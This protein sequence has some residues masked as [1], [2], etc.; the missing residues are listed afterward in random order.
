[1]KAV[2]SQ[3]WPCVL[4]SACCR[5]SACHTGT[6]TTGGGVSRFDVG[7]RSFHFRALH[8]T[9]VKA[10]LTG[11]RCGGCSLAFWGEDKSL[12][13]ERQLRGRVT[14]AYAPCA[15]PERAAGEVGERISRAA[16]H[17][18]IA[19]FCGGSPASRPGTREP[20]DGAETPQPIPGV[21]HQDRS[22]ARSTNL[23]PLKSC[24]PRSFAPNKR[25]N[26]SFAPNKRVYNNVM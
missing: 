2:Y 19:P 25:Y 6:G 14:P 9:K 1:M 24:V 18:S 13:N 5:W 10:T 4:Q 23:G 3:E 12:A 15:G 22:R 17:P 7:S 11:P 26:N 20:Y 21:I 16:P 8:G